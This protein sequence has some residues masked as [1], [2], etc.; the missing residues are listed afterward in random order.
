MVGMWFWVI[1]VK[2]SVKRVSDITEKYYNFA[3]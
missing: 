2:I 3:S 1:M